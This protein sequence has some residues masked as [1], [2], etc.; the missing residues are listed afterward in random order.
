MACVCLG[1]EIHIRI[2]DHFA[3]EED[4]RLFVE[5]LFIQIEFSLV[6]YYLFKKELI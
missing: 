2:G 1:S 4:N 6:M 5:C 3:S